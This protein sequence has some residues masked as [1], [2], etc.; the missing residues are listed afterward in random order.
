MNPRQ[1]GQPPPQPPVNRAM[2]AKSPASLQFSKIQME[3]EL[4]RKRQEDLQ[5]QVRDEEK[6][7]FSFIEIWLKDFYAE[8]TFAFCKITRASS[9]KQVVF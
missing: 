3:K 4:L 5:R 1:M 8:S 6:N 9:V 7:C 2:G